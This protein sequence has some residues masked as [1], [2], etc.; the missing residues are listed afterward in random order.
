MDLLLPEYC[1]KLKEALRYDE[2]L[3]TTYK[4]KVKNMLNSELDDIGIYEVIPSLD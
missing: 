2:T 4:T 3:L 1:P